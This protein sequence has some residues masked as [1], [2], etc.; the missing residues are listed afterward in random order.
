MI[1]FGSGSFLFSVLL[2]ILIRKLFSYIYKHYFKENFMN[3][4]IN[5]LRFKHVLQH[6]VCLVYVKNLEDKCS[7]DMLKAGKDPQ[8][9]P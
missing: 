6:H 7:P 4:H 2:L 3:T 9:D 1:C 5:L 8:L